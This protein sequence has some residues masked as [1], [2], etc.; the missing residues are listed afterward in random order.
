MKVKNLVICMFV[1]TIVV[2]VNQNCSKV[3]F[4]SS[5]D[6]ESKVG[7]SS[8]T[9]SNLR[10]YTDSFNQG[11]GSVDILFVVD[12][13]LS[14]YE[15]QT[16]LA[17]QLNSFLQGLGGTDWQIGITTTDIDGGYYSTNGKLLNFESQGRKFNVLDP[18]VQNAA[19]L[20]RHTM[21]RDET[22]YC[23]SPDSDGGKC[24]SQPSS[25]EKPFGAIIEAIKL[26]NTTN[27]A[28]F[29]PNADLAFV[30]LSDEDDSG[31]DTP[32][33]L[34]ETFTQAWGYE[35]RVTVH[36]LIIEPGD[37]N[38]YNEQLAQM[39]NANWA[40]YGR[41]ITRAIRYTNGVVGSICTV[42]YQ[43][44]L[45]NIGANISANSVELAKIPEELI[46]ITVTNTHGTN[47]DVVPRTG[48]NVV[49]NKI[50]FRRPIV[51]GSTIDVTY[52]ARQN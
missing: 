43:D 40:G 18:E 37:E 48:Y 38:C 12:N 50:I 46:S 47:V 4:T 5:G 9:N 41:D 16:K 34:I 32:E 33:N 30:I 42:D 29:R 52:L 26:R 23:G 19:L 51:A 27:Q 14:M 2:G 11:S 45:V 28:F 7:L 10:T 49:K 6:N 24:V 17:N 39:N 20:F 13:S 15:E 36:G 22:L 31:A 35:K 25:D 3:K 21:R 1:L 44:I 8:N